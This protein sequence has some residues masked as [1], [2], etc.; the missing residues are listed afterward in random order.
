MSVD[1]QNLPSD[2]LARELIDLYRR[3]QANLAVEITRLVAA[4]RETTAANRRR[5]LAAVLAYLHKLGVDTDPLA[6]QVVR[7]AVRD[8]NLLAVESSHAIGITA[9]TVSER[10]FAAV[11]EQAIRVATGQ[12]VGR[13]K[14]ARVA[15]GR[16]IN[17]VF[18]RATRRTVVRALLGEA[19]SPDTATRAMVRELVQA[20]QTAFTDTAGRQW[21]LERYANM[22]VRTA[23]RQAVVEGQINRLAAGG[24]DLARVSTHANSCDVCKQYEGRLITLS[25]NLDPLFGEIP[26]D[27]PLPPFH[28]NCRHTIL[29]VSRRVE[30]VRREGM[31]TNA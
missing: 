25:G 12:L 13:L 21:K 15:T 23:T 3:A 16:A 10:S 19:G 27:G 31:A 24:I 18:A 29:A 8:G 2:R 28:P 6:E 5:Q 4:G 11:N 9:M 14:D 30:A 17:D 1:D 26:A 22:A 7:Q 20:G